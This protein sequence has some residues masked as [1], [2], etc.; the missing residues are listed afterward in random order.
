MTG[1]TTGTTGPPTAIRV[2]HFDI[3]SIPKKPR[4][5][6]RRRIEAKR[7]RDRVRVS[8]LER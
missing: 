5:S 7:W 1:T 8:D 2:V 4:P 6:M 3:R